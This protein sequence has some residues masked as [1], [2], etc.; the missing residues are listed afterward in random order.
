MTFRSREDKVTTDRLKLN[1]TDHMQRLARGVPNVKNNNND[2]PI[3]KEGK[4]TVCVTNEYDRDKKM[5]CRMNTDNQ[6]ESEV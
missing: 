4:V 1:C 5:K 2:K 6:N 3:I